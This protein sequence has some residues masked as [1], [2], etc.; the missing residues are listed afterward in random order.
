MAPGKIKV[1]ILSSFSLIFF[2]TLLRGA[3]LGQYVKYL[4]LLQSKN[5]EQP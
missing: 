5:L 2:H 1:T 4:D 3:Y